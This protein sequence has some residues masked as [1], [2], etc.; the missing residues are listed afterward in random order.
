[1]LNDDQR[2]FI[3]RA[4]HLRGRW[5][6]SVQNPVVLSVL[7]LLALLLSS[8]SSVSQIAPHPPT[9]TSPPTATLLP[10]PTAPPLGPVP[11]DCPPGPTPQTF[12]PAIGIVVGA[13]PV[14]VAGLV[15]P[16]A[17]LVWGP[18]E[19]AQYHTSNGWIHKFRY[20]V[21]TNIGGLVTIEGANLKDNAP[22]RPSADDQA[23]T[24]T[25][26]RLVLD[27]QDPYITNRIGQWT[28]FPG[29]LTIPE[30]GCYMLE[31]AWPGGHWQITFAAGEVPSD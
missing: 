8:C 29:G 5:A 16:H 25:A 18:V 6:V 13:G 3:R 26:T 17:E 11:Q 22:L 15:G 24:S 19:A 14:W 9:G 21:A 28:N 20:I 31:A 7:F 27:T 30:A 10:T 12:D 1:M 2:E 4:Y 23:S